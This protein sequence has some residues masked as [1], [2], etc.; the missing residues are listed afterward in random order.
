MLSCALL[1]ALGLARPA[2]AGELTPNNTDAAVLIRGGDAGGAWYPLPADGS[3]TFDVTGPIV[4]TVE[5][6][7][8]LADD[9]ATPTA[10]VKAKGDGMLILNVKV[11]GRPGEGAIMDAQ[12]G[13]ASRVDR[14]EITV[15]AGEH[16]FSLESSDPAAQLLV[17]V[18]AED[19]GAQTVDL[20][21]LDEPDPDEPVHDPVVDLDQVDPVAL[22]DPAEPDPIVQA[23]PIPDPPLDPDPVMDDPITDA[24]DSITDEEAAETDLTVEDTGPAYVTD[25]TDVDV[26]R[27]TS[28]QAR[29]ELGVRTGLGNTAGGNRLSW[30]M[31]VEALFPTRNE[32]V[33]FGLRVGR[34][35]SNLDTQVAVQP[36]IGVTATAYDVA[37][38]TRIRPAEAG[39]RYT[40]GLGPI[41][42]Y[43]WAGLAGYWS[44]RI[45]DDEKLQ[46][47]S[48]GTSWALG[49][50]LPMGPG[51]LSPELAVNLGRRTFGNPSASGDTAREK[52]SGSRV[53]VA[54][55]FAF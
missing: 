40:L 2:D 32:R 23:D 34:Y 7:Q 14:A 25:T 46:G 11:S 37:W 35:G 43:G 31:G 42:A 8:R 36:A 1:L 21:A 6:V 41:D 54:Y 53:N 13:N 9:D 27:P 44:T 15:P 33:G 47:I 28:D 48:L 20:V 16:V 17:R 24:A 29:F 19:T 22:D 18:L 3:L 26:P 30:Y 52:L 55:R 38:K 5:A 51:T 12:G 39:V 45:Q 49:V 50:D 4:L 10:Q